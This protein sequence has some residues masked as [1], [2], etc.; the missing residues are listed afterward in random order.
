M[1]RTVVWCGV[2]Y[3]TR[4]ISGGK[5]IVVYSNLAR[6]KVQHSKMDGDG[7]AEN[8]PTFQSERNK[9]I[10]KIQHGNF[11]IYRI[12]I[13]RLQVIWT[14]STRYRIRRKNDDA[15]GASKLETEAGA[16]PSLQA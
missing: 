8:T 3:S 5:S 2:V 9:E 16:T 14:R 10:L 6:F 4:T 15:S 12:D 7:N 11:G 13:L 1:C